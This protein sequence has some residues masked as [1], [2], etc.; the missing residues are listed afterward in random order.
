[1][2]M[3]V[4]GANVRCSGSIA[5][6]D[7]LRLR[8]AATAACAAAGLDTARA[9]Q[10]VLALSE[11]VTNAITHA[12]GCRELRIELVDDALIADVIAAGPGPDAAA[13]PLNVPAPDQPHGRGLWLIRRCVDR[14]E[15]SAH[16]VGHRI[17]L[18]IGVGIQAIAALSRH[19]ALAH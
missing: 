9:D 12:G 4:R 11:V 19:T 7:L 5:A 2:I 14:I 15:I 8:H 13:F 16:R 1:M 6:D 17:R 3:S 18:V 10:F